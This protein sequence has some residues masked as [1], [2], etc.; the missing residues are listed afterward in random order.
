MKTLR[1]KVKPNAYRWLDAA[2]R[3][4]NTRLELV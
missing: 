4:V 1:L 2:A 3:E